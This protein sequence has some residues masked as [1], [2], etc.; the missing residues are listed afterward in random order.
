MD[1]LAVLFH[2][3]KT[4]GEAFTSQYSNGLTFS[5]SGFEIELS[6]FWQRVYSLEITLLKKNDFEFIAYEKSRDYEDS[7][8]LKMKLLEISDMGLSNFRVYSKDEAVSGR[9]INASSSLELLAQ[10]GFTTT[11]ATSHFLKSGK[12]APDIDADLRPENVKF[13]IERLADIQKNLQAR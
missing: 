5:H 3:K 2:G 13:I 10:K 1:E 9:I 4:A 7:K 6:V 11:E 12:T 8:T